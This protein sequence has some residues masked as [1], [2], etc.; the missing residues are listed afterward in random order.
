MEVVSKQKILLPS[1]TKDFIIFHQSIFSLAQ[2]GATSKIGD[3]EDIST[4]IT[5]GFRVTL[6]EI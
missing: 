3:F 1:V 4:L 5:Y 2:K 6:I